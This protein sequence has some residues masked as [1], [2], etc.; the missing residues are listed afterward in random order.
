LESKRVVLVIAVLFLAGLTF[1][2]LARAEL[3]EGTIVDHFNETRSGLTCLDPSAMGTG[4]FS[5]TDMVHFTQ[6]SGTYYREQTATENFNYTM[7]SGTVFSG[8]DTFHATL[9]MVN[10]IVA[11]RIV[12]WNGEAQGSDGTLIA[13]TILM[14]SNGGNVLQDQYVC[15]TPS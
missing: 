5:G 10:G 9:R 11:T 14:V 2:P 8:H 4:T 3:S 7:P 15:G 12:S 6:N 13:W 1:T